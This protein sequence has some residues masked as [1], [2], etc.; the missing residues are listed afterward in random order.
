MK[1]ISIKSKIVAAATLLVIGGA[2]VGLAV[3]HQS[4]VSAASASQ[5]DNRS[6]GETNDDSKATTSN[7]QDNGQDGE[8]ND[9]VNQ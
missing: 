2:G 1:S 7:V 6:D 8:T 3:A 9:S 5:I 4:R